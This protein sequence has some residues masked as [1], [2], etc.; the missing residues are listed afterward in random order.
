MFPFHLSHVKFRIFTTDMIYTCISTLVWKH[1]H[2]LEFASNANHYQQQH[3][4][5]LS[6]WSH[7]VDIDFSTPFIA[8]VYQRDLEVYHIDTGQR[9]TLHS[10]P[11]SSS[12]PSSTP[13]TNEFLHTPAYIRLSYHA[14]IAVAWYENSSNIDFFRISHHELSHQHVIKKIDR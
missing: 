2:T 8:R 13:H 3:E 9:M 1:L 10:N 5:T 11:T 12:L 4:S 14:N 7:I 6:S